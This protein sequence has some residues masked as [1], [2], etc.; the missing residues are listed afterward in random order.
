[1]QRKKAR[2]TGFT[3]IELLIAITIIG[4]LVAVGL[5]SFGS[6]QKKARDSKR[7]TD[8]QSISRA[9]EL[10]YNDCGAY[11]LTGNNNVIAGCGATGSCNTSASDCSWGGVFTRNGINYMTEIPSDP[12]GNYY[13]VSNGTSYGLYARLENTSDS[14]VPHNGTTPQGY[15]TTLC[16]SAAR[17]NYGIK[18]S[19]AATLGTTVDD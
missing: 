7:K 6:A 12:M 10:Y 3:L 11:P 17:C 19:N 9:L 5:G 14:A 2:K 13:Y 8:L 4:I 16:R 18:S 15:E 1:M